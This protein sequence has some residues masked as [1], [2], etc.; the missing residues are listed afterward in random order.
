MGAIQIV[1][2]ITDFG[3]K[4]KQNRF[5]QLLLMSKCDIICSVKADDFWS[6]VFLSPRVLRGFLL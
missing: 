4:I 2:I 1:S 3:I 6:A 5:L